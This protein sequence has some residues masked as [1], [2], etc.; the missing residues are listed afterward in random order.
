MDPT[1]PNGG[2]LMVPRLPFRVRELQRVGARLLSGDLGSR[3]VLSRRELGIN[4]LT[5]S[6]NA[7]QREGEELGAS[8]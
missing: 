3:F 2:G 1:I 8:W 4:K 6:G 7:G 5:M